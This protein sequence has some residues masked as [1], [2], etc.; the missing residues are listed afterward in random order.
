MRTDSA[1]GAGHMED[2]ESVSGR[3]YRRA[4]RGRWWP[5]YW[6]WLR[7]ATVTN[8]LLTL[9]AIPTGALGAWLEWRLLSPDEP[10]ITW[11]KAIITGLIAAACVTGAYLLAVASR[12]YW[13]RYRARVEEWT[14]NQQAIAARQRRINELEAPSGKLT[15]EAILGTYLALNKAMMRLP[16]ISSVSPENADERWNDLGSAL[17]RYE[18]AY[19]TLTPT[20]Q[21]AHERIFAAFRAGN[22]HRSVEPIGEAGDLLTD[23]LFRG[24]YDLEIAIADLVAVPFRRRDPAARGPFAVV[25]LCVTNRGDEQVSLLP[26]WCLKVRY[27]SGSY[28]TSYYDPDAEPLAAWEERRHKV[29]LLPAA[30]WLPVPLNLPA[31]NSAL[32]YWSF[33]LSRIHSFLPGGEIQPEGFLEIEDR[34]TGKRARSEPK[35]FKAAE[36]LGEQPATKAD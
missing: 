9:A 27:G 11:R 13:S 6:T 26:N 28:G 7:R 35:P 23:I 34:I 1:G 3:P 2:D 19:K 16:G 15:K 20:A 31:K 33:H 14:A 4:V 30:A 22:T 18:A 10:P 32:G 25:L 21:V 17:E 29:H 24:E 12:L 8:V 36:L 5:K